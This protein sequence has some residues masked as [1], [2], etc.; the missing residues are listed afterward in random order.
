MRDGLPLPVNT[1]FHVEVLYTGNLNVN[2]VLDMKS[3]DNP[4]N[5]IHPSVVI[6]LEFLLRVFA[7]SPLNKFTLHKPH[8][9]L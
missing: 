5:L 6:V 1:L 3:G 8:P 2:P 9:L 4:Q 7:D